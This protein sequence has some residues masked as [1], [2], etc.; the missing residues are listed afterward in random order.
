M[1]NP[2]IDTSRLDP[3]FDQPLAVPSCLSAAP[4]AT[5]K[6][7]LV[8]SRV[9]DAPFRSVNRVHLRGIARWLEGD[10]PDS[11]FQS[12][13]SWVGRSDSI[14][15][16]DSGK[17]QDRLAAGLGQNPLLGVVENRRTRR[18]DYQ[19]FTAQDVKIL[20]PAAIHET[21]LDMGGV[22]IAHLTDRLERLIAH[23]FGRRF[24]APERGANVIAEPAA[25]LPNDEVILLFGASVF[26]PN[27]KDERLCDMELFVDT[28]SGPA[29]VPEVFAFSFTRPFADLPSCQS[30]R[31]PAALYRKQTSLLISPDATR[32][33]LVLPAALGLPPE[34]SLQIGLSPDRARGDGVFFQR[35]GT[36]VRES[37]GVRTFR[38]H[39]AQPSATPG[40]NIAVE[41]RIVPAAPVKAATAVPPP[42]GP[43]DRA[44]PLPQKIGKPRRSLWAALVGA[45]TPKPGAGRRAP[46]MSPHPPRTMADARHT[47]V[48]TGEALASLDADP[49]HLAFSPASPYRLSV[50]ALALP[51][52][53]RLPGGGWG[54]TS[55]TLALTEAGEITVRPVGRAGAET[56][57]L[58]ILGGRA[59]DANLFAIPAGGG[60]W[61]VVPEDGRMALLPDGREAPLL[62]APGLV[63]ERYHMLLKL[64]RPRHFPLLGS[65]EQLIGRQNQNAAAGDGALP[66]LQFGLLDLPGSMDVPD[67]TME[68]V[69]LSR[70][71]VRAWIADDRLMVAMHA[72]RAPVWRLDGGFEAVEER[73]PGGGEPLTLVPGDHLLLGCYVLQFGRTADPV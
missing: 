6:P 43:R 65:G 64:P 17:P 11:L 38:F 23:E 10:L 63:A 12:P 60:A 28:G 45:M 39:Q 70:D 34:A 32:A 48:L 58:A 5:A 31:R 14:V 8:A 41:I 71:H 1:D 72:G 37:G 4:P 62:P 30:I 29:P 16:V 7:P 35:E 22:P 46:D 67:G 47:I 40:Q 36:M 44:G 61:V 54:P 25:S 9:Q 27:E 49:L 33:P 56:L 51:R 18:H 42:A 13:S 2:T 24:L 3:I 55:W 20:L 15:N 57:K 19:E 59:G 68:M 26:V 52:L 69:N 53:P 66:K 73:Q 50:V 21:F